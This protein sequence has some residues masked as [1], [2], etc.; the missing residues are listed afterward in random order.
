MLTL[1]STLALN[2]GLAVDFDVETGSDGD[3]AGEQ[4]KHPCWA[5]RAPRQRSA[6][7]REGGKRRS[8]CY[9]RE[10]GSRRRGLRAI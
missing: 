3:R 10:I 2:L 4:T 5:R 1:A 6:S 8:L 7:F 9:A